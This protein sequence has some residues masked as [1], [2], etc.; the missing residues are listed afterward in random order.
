[1]RIPEA[2]LDH[3]KRVNDHCGYPV[4]DSVFAAGGELLREIKRPTDVVTRFG[5]EEFVVLMPHTTGEPAK[6]IAERIRVSFAL[7]AFRQSKTRC[8]SAAASRR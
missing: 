6:A 1:V 7:F 4:G 3:F 5:G 8:L 2:D